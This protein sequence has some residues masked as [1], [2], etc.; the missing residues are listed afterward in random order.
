MQQ[1]HTDFIS[2]RQSK[3]GLERLGTDHIDLYYL[4]RW[5]ASTRIAESLRALDDC[6][7]QGKVRYIAC[8]NFQAWRVCEA[9]WTSEKYGLEVR[10]CPAA[11]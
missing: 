11:L 6:V 8:S 4:H 10:V 2:C 5:D 9:L 1:V 7:R 3:R